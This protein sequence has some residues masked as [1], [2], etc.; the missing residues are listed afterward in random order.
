MVFSFAN[1]HVSAAALTEGKAPTRQADPCINASI[2]SLKYRM[3]ELWI[4]HA[5]WTRSFIVSSLAGLE[6]KEHVLDRL[7]KNQV[8][9][10]NEIKPFYG[11]AA[12]NKLT[13]LLKEHI[14][15]AGHLVEAAKKNDK[16]NVDKYNKEWFRNADIIVDFL[17]TAN[18]NWSRKVL[19][20]MFQTHL[21]LTID[22]VTDRLNEDWEGDIRAA[23]L[24][25]THLIHL[26]DFLTDGIVKQF[27]EKFN[28]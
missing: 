13:E 23:D 11:E 9:I 4:E 3:Q 25:E 15:I 18:P 24:N 10:G 28:K 14:L 20:D 7:L 12:G 16:A 26:G 8:E 19:T 5:W 6:D 2:I 1:F 22:E 21:K 27:P 17:S